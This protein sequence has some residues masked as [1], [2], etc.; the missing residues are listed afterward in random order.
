MAI[1][2]KIVEK[3]KEKTTNDKFLRQSLMEVLFQM[4]EGRQPKRIIDKEIEKL[5]KE[6]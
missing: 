5:P 1:N 6:D 2:P 3:I 4:E